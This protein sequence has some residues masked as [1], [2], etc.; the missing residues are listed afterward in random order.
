MESL[1]RVFAWRVEMVHQNVCIHG[2]VRVLAIDLRISSIKPHILMLE[3]EKPSLDYT[4]SCNS[5]SCHT[6]TDL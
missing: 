5:F 1:L 6:L 2:I 4:F 3:S